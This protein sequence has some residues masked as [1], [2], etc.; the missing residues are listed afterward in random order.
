[1]P[2]SAR[3]FALATS[4]RLTLINSSSQRV[5]ASLNSAN[6]AS[7][8]G[9]K[10]SVDSSPESLDSTLASSAEARNCMRRQ[11]ATAQSA[12]VDNRQDAKIHHV[13]AGKDLAC[14]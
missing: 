13:L 8:E 5:S 2:S 12:A 11:Y 3:A 6:V 14:G 1:M 9:V 7:L 10:R 4:R